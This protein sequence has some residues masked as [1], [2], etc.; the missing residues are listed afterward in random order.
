[1][2]PLD[3]RSARAS[4]DVARPVIARLGTGRDPEDNA[5][6]LI[7]GWGA[8][9]TALRSSLGGTALAGQ[10]LVRELRQR[11]LLGFNDAHAVLD[12]LAARER[13]GRVDYQP[14]AIDFAAARDGFQAV[15]SRVLT[16]GPAAPAPPSDYAPLATPGHA[17][18][19][20]D[21]AASGADYG[22]PVPA[23]REGRGPGVI[24]GGLLAVL[25]AVLA[26]TYFYTQRGADEQNAALTKGI[27][28]YKARSPVAARDQFLQAVRTDT[29]NVLAHV[30]LARVS[31][32]LGDT[33]AA[34]SE[35]SKAVNL[36]PNNGTA[37]REMGS[38]MLA[39]RKND[40][41]R[42]FYVRAIVADTSD[43]DAKGLLSCALA[44]LGSPEADKWLQRAGP[45]VW[46]QCVDAARSVRAPVQGAAPAPGRRL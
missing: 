7:E 44:R 3:Q 42:R 36:D 40:L 19:I 45:G 21:V 4:L 11:E 35:A 25:L 30:Y 2:S 32:D 27:E 6:D 14:T 20:A 24:I 33:V 22:T 39:Q 38:L 15:E 31:R 8:V 9:E 28:L 13:A 17:S 10:A 29:T 1:M 12:F 23:Q 34:V 26:G 5:A 18:R 41:A 46:T 37:L 16:G 43:R